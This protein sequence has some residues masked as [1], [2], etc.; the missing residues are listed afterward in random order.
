V[1][2]DDGCDL[3]LAWWFTNDARAAASERRRASH[4]LAGAILPAR[5]RDVLR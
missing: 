3:S 1:P 5:C 2:D 4:R